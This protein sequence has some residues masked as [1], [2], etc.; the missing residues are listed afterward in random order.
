MLTIA[1]AIFFFATAKPL[2]ALAV[3]FGGAFGILI[4]RGQICFTAAFRDMWLT[5]QST[6]MK[7]LIIGLGTATI[8]T[9]F[10]I[11]SVG[12]PPR[13]SPWEWAPSWAVCS[14][15]WGSCWRAPAKPA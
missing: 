5:G 14:S 7:A 10:V 6:M 11:A 9:F 3:I 15:G 4:Q 13:S 8:A 12:K 1:I 2:I